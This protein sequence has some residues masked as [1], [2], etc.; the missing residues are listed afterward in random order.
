MSPEGLGAWSSNGFG[1]SRN[2]GDNAYKT[3]AM[4]LVRRMPGERS[5][6]AFRGPCNHGA[7]GSVAV[8]RSAVQTAEN[9]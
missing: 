2:E 1:H 5:S 8:I 9:G 3:V 4:A 7:S 6:P